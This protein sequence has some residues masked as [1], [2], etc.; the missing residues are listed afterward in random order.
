MCLSLW[1]SSDSLSSMGQLER[2][3]RCL[4][5][6]LA[7]PLVRWKMPWKL[8]TRHSFSNC[9][10]VLCKSSPFCH[11]FDQHTNWSSSTLENSC[12]HRTET[13]HSWW[14]T[15]SDSRKTK[16]GLFSGILH[17]FR[18]HESFMQREQAEKDACAL[19]MPSAM[20]DSTGGYRFQNTKRL[21]T[22][23]SSKHRLSYGNNTFLFKTGIC[24]YYP[25]FIQYWTIQ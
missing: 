13:F 17:R 1:R 11:L 8:A 24:L 19:F 21:F 18:L 7:I 14:T 23:P 15:A 4:Q 3:I 16:E 12:I 9:F 10:V 5:F 2:W 6:H 20:F 22:P 25:C